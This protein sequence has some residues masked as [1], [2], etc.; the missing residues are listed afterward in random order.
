MNV[1][2]IADLHLS[3][4]HPDPRERFAGRWADHAAKIERNWREIVRPTDVVLIPG[5]VSNA[6]NHR[7]LQPDLA[8]L[9]RLPGTKILS[10]G[11]H[12]AWFNGAARVRPLLRRSL[13]V[14]GGDAVAV[15][16]LIACGT[17]GA[18]VPTDDGTPS[19]D[20]VRELAALDR[21]LAQALALRTADEPIF[22]LW[23]YPPFDPHNRPGPAVGPLS[24]AKVTACVSG[25]VHTEGQWSGAYQGTYEGVRYAC[26]AA[27]SVGFRPLR[28]AELP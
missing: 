2:A 16:G 26:V 13:R 27:D 22:A 7:D 11:N 24:A 25:H 9:D 5:D 4:A 28:I 6:R 12:D 10:A 14:V 17:L 19:P 20:L 3:V 18:P 23:H 15:G 21:A 8:W 1:W